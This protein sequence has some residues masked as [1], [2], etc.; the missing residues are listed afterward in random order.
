MIAG[1]FTLTFRTNWRL[2]EEDEGDIEESKEERSAKR[3]EL[4]RPRTPEPS[5][6]GMRDDNFDC[7]RREWSATPHRHPTPVSLRR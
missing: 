6:L 1:A 7:S 4:G 5:S 2:Q 3:E